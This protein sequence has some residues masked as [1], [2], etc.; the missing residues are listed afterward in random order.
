[1]DC[2]CGIVNAEA[3]DL[4]LRGRKI[5]E[6]AQLPFRDLGIPIKKSKIIDNTED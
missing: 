2:K 4:I 3:F 1:M 5:A 6:T